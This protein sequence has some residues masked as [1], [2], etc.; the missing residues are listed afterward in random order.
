MRRGGACDVRGRGL[1]CGTGK[2]EI[3]AFLEEIWKS[4]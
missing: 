3:A 2:T 4:G 1:L